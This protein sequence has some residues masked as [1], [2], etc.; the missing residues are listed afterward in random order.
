MNSEFFSML[1]KLSGIRIKGDR[2]KQFLQSHVTANLNDD[3]TLLPSALCNQKG[4]VVSL[5]FIQKIDDSHYQLWL[6][7][8][9]VDLTLKPLSKT[10]P[11]SRITLEK[12][13]K[14]F[15]IG[16]KSKEAIGH[17]ATLDFNYSEELHLLIAE[18]EAEQSSLIN[19]FSERTLEEQKPFNFYKAIMYEHWFDLKNE[20]SK[21]FL[22][23]RLGLLANG[24]VS[25][26]KG[27]YIG[28]EIIARLH[29]KSE[30]KYEPYICD[31]A[32]NLDINETV[33]LDDKA[34]GLV[35]DKIGEEPNEVCYAL[36]LRKDS[37]ERFRSST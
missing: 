33:L 16:L 19:A 30:E 13:H 31:K 21:A 28:H 17:D 5:F 7:D 8:A 3:F 12:T 37:V 18:S 23:N 36:S 34:I 32:L 2:A 11:L 35:L 29:F 1:P 22:P 14:A 9:L 4:R 15:A 6:Q 26:N 25:V 10:A 27:C 24:V 20:A